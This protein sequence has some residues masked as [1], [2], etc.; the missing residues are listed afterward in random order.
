MDLEE[1]P[2]LEIHIGE[3]DMDIPNNAISTT[4]YNVLTFFPKN[5]FWQYTKMSN[6]YFLVI[7]IPLKFLFLYHRD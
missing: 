1:Y 6:L 5:L 2:D 3:P 4:K 7:N